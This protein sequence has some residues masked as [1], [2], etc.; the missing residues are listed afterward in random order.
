MHRMHEN[1]WWKSF[2]IAFITAVILSLARIPVVGNA[3]GISVATGANATLPQEI[4][5]GENTSSSMDTED[6]DFVFEILDEDVLSVELPVLP[7][8][9]PFDFILDPY[10]LL[11]ETSA[12]RYGGGL[13]EEGATLLFSNRSGKYDFSRDSDLLTVTNQTG[14]PVRVKVSASVRDLDKIALLESADFLEADNPGLYLAIRDSQGKE[15]P[16]VAGREA[17]IGMELDS[18]EYSFGLTGACSPDADWQGISIRPRVTVTW[19]V[20]SVMAEEDDEEEWESDWRDAR[21]A[22]PSSAW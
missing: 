4:A 3:A 11:Y 18:G 2:R 17:S 5:E 9:S 13:V 22:S 10:G 6:E 16:I 19:H 20:E 8:E 7:E 21:P 15:Q 14:I 1:K 12:I